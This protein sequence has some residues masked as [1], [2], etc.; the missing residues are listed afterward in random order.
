MATNPS[1]RS[2]LLVEAILADNAV[3]N[4]DWSVTPLQ[5][6]NRLRALVS[7]LIGEDPRRIPNVLAPFITQLCVGRREKLS[8]FGDDSPARHGTGVCNCI[9]VVDIGQGHLAALRPRQPRRPR[10]QPGYGDGRLAAGDGDDVRGG[11]RR[12]DPVPGRAAAVR[13]HRRM[14]RRPRPGGAGPQLA[15][16]ALTVE[17]MAAD[18]WRWQEG[19]PTGGPDWT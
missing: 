18:A 1:G 12:S 10:D 14:P 3:V 16:D 7:G 9:H 4:P 11:L 8:A 19:D 13:R 15:G 17:E 5:Y 6:C 2:K